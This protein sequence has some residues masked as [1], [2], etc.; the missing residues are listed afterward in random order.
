MKR[1]VEDLAAL[2]YQQIY[3]WVLEENLKARS[4][5][6]QNGFSST[7]DKVQVEIDGKELQ[8]MRYIYAV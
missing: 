1:A 5:Y 8:E 4:F 3:L 2:G 6:E 7:T